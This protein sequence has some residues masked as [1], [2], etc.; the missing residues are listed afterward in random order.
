MRKASFVLLGV[1]LLLLAMTITA[2]AYPRTVLMEDF[3]NWG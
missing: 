1:G 2:G 3:T